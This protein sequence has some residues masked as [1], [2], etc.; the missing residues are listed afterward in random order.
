MPYNLTCRI[1][2]FWGFVKCPVFWNEQSCR[3]QIY[4]HPQKTEF[5]S[6]YWAGSDRK[7]YSKTFCL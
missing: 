2:C 5:G 1:S 7:S 4:F 6:T 3:N